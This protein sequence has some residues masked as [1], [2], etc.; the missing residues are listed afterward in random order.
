[1]KTKKKLKNFRFIIAIDI[2]GEDIHGAYKKLLIRMSGNDW[3]T[4]DEA[5]DTDG[6]VIDLNNTIFS[7]NFDKKEES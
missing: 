5:Y 4:T 3:E 2:E 7:V 1:M 6:N